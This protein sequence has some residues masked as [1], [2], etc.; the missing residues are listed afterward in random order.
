MQNLTPKVCFL[1]DGDVRFWEK[2][3]LSLRLP[4]LNRK[5]SALPSEADVRL[6]LTKGAANDPKRTLVTDYRFAIQRLYLGHLN[7]DKAKPA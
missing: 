1:G 5:T 6:R 4:K 3:T 2:R 7:I